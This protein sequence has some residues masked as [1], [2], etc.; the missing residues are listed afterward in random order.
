[1]TVE[2][3][4]CA[5]CGSCCET[6]WLSRKARESIEAEIAYDDELAENAAFLLEHWTEKERDAIGDTRYECDAY[7]KDHHLCTAREDRPPVCRDFPWYGE[8]PGRFHGIINKR[9][10]YWLDVPPDMRPDYVERPLIPI[11]AITR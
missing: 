7:D 8:E 11:T 1:M 3:L 2:S 10:S 6:I 5:R 9:C 4:G